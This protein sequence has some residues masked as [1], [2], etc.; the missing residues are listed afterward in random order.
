[1]DEKAEETKISGVGADQPRCDWIPMGSK[2]QVHG[3]EQPALLPKKP[4][5]QILGTWTLTSKPYR[6]LYILICLH[7][8]TH[9]YIYIS[10]ALQ[11]LDTLTL[12]GRLGFDKLRTSSIAEAKRHGC[13]LLGLLRALMTKL[14]HGCYIGDYIGESCRA[15]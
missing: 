3:Q 14:L 4:A 5:T 10:L 13:Q 15:Y 2:S 12:G 6:S 11:E 8:H 9:I 1:M 7:T